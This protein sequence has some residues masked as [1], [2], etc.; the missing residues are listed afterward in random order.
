MSLVLHGTAVEL[1]GRGLLITGASGTGKSQLAL[2]MIGLG[3]RLIADDQVRVD[4]GT[5]GLML[6]PPANLA[7]LIEVWGI[8]LIRLPHLAGVALWGIAD[9]D[10]AEA[11]RLPPP[12]ARAVAGQQVPVWACRG[13]PGLAAALAALMRAGRVLPGDFRPGIALP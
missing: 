2:E 13:R 12:R 1:E 3:A 7:G 5:P 10:A 6:A 9:L 4:A 8:G 11:E